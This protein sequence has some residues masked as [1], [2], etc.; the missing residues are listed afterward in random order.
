[1]RRSL[2]IAL[3]VL[4]YL[5][6]VLGPLA[7]LLLGPRPEGRE[8]W[9]EFA[10]GLGF[11]G[12]SLMGLQFV[13]TARLPGLGN[14]LPMDTLYSFHHRLALVAL[15]LM[16]AHPVVLAANNPNILRLLNPV[17]A[18]WGARA[19]VAALLCAAVLVLTSVRRKELGIQYE[20][21][22]LVHALL[23]AAAAILALVHVF[24]ADHYLALPLQRA[25]W[26]AVPALW[27]GM[28]L[29]VRV[30]RPL[31]LLRRP[32]GIVEVRPERGDSWTLALA[33]NGHRGLTFR[34]GQVAWLTVQRFPWAI[35][36][37]PFS[38]SSSAERPEQIEF[39]IR[40]LGDFTST[41][42]ELRPGTCAA[43]DCVYVDGPYGIFDLERADIS[44]LVLIAG[45]IGAGP[46]M[47]ILRTMA[48]RGDRRPVIFFYGNRSWDA[49]TFREDLEALRQ[50]LDLTLVH[51]LERPPEGWT[52]ETGFITAAM[53]DRYLPPDR[54]TR[55][56]FVCG[57]LPMM[58]VVE[59]AL[60]TLRVPA[61][62]VHVEKYEMA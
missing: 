40:E 51:I 36:E 6:L 10:V 4:A 61:T 39:T 16:A 18:T 62:H 53:L 32:Y 59:R 21:W 56:Y 25:I 5:L 44:G 41:V 26:I 28:V 3:W 34:P 20:S 43:G 52:G 27:L 33:P 22:R 60:H 17:T 14:V 9:R 19:G 42:K 54:A 24:R 58:R 57:P 2:R 1:M 45:G 48:D 38:F 49:V 7:A 8:F 37:H 47:S 12:L 23:A 46:V 50:R 31:Y 13:P 29:Y 35:R 30:I 15:A 11:A 55:L